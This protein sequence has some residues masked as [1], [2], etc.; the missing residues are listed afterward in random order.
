MAHEILSVK[1]NELDERICR[2][3]SRIHLSE[4]SDL[5]TLD[6]ELSQMEKECKE[7]CQAHSYK[8]HHSHSSSLVRLAKAYDVVEDEI[9]ELRLGR[10]A[11]ESADEKIL[12]AEYALD[13]ALLA[14]E[15]ALCEALDAV[16]ASLYEERR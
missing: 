7:S 1:L 8:L 2:I 14:A 13:F 10:R 6:R 4:S 16:K 11:D 15:R 12:L 5:K 9:K 3:H